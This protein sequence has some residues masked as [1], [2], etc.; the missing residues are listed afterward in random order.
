M[1]K[2]K[3]EKTNFRGLE[4]YK[5]ES[6]KHG[7]KFDRYFRGRFTVNKQ[8]KA[9]GL[10]WASEG[11]DE[12][13]AYMKIQEYRENLKTGAGPT[14]PKEEEAAA[15][16]AAERERAE[17]EAAA[18]AA[19]LDAERLERE[20]VT[21]STFWND[22]YFPAAKVDKAFNTSRTEEAYFKKWIQPQIGNLPI[23][24]VKPSDIERIK[25]ALLNAPP[26]NGGKVTQK[27]TSPVG[28]SPRLIEYVLAITRQIFNQAERLGFRQGDNPCRHVKKPKVANERKRFLTH[29]EADDLL[30]ELKERTPQLHDLAL[31]SLR[32]GLRA[33]EIFNLQWADVDFQREQ[34]L[35]RDPKGGRNRHAYLTPEVI[36]MLKRQPRT[37]NKPSELVF[38]SRKGGKVRAV[39]NAFGRTI[40]KLG[41]NYGITDPR[42]KLTFHSLRHSFASQLVEAGISLPV[43]KE[44]LGHATLKMTERYS[45]V[46]PGLA[47]KAISSLDAA[48]KASRTQGKVIPFEKKRSSAN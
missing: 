14:S 17:A 11:W 28:R 25:N 48:A 32:T 20:A 37:E 38:K 16:K 10:G 24:E 35:V 1:A 3:W 46:G 8:T 41:L 5:H 47:R 30:T 29:A 13:K 40:L 31:L 18:M 9:V 6:R 45:H 43:V 33:G 27:K 34:M 7:V 22:Y 19:K 2:V 36:E 23:K 44:L 26:K 12:T 39:S 15:R 21:V 4:F 42:H